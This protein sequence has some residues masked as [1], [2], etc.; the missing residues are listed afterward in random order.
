MSQRQAC[1][2]SRCYSPEPIGAAITVGQAAVGSRATKRTAGLRHLWRVGNIARPN[3]R[4]DTTV[5]LRHDA[6]RGIGDPSRH[7]V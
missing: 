2:G 6:L 1:D 7:R 3:D 5:A 4:L